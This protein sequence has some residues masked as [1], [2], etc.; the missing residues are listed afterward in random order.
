MNSCA[1]VGFPQRVAVFDLG[2]G[3]RDL[4]GAM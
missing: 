4:L 1:C 2:L 3:G